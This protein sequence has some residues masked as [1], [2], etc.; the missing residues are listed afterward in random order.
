MDSIRAEEF[1][2]LLYILNSHT[3]RAGAPHIS[4][5]PMREDTET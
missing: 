1:Q 2:A 5:L 3:Q 4:H